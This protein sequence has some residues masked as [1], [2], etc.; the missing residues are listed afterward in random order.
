MRVMGID[1]TPHNIKPFLWRHPC[2][3]NLFYPVPLADDVLGERR[4]PLDRRMEPELVAERAEEAPPSRVEETFLPP[5][6]RFDEL[7]SEE[8]CLPHGGYIRSKVS[9][10]SLRA[11]S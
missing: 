7:A 9:I 10:A 11:F 5:L 2:G 6:Y 3:C 8:E 1:D 4:S